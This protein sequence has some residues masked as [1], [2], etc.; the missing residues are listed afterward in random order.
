MKNIELQ[1]S[2]LLSNGTKTFDLSVPF[3]NGLVYGGELCPF[4]LPQEP[5]ERPLHWYRAEEF[6]AICDNQVGILPKIEKGIN[7]CHNL[8]AHGLMAVVKSRIDNAGFITLNRLISE[9]DCY[10]LLKFSDSQCDTETIKNEYDSVLLYLI[11]SIPMKIIYGNPAKIIT[12]CR[13]F[14]WLNPEK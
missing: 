4:Q 6:V 8:L 5:N 13:L 7:S 10:S 14:S 2:V 12:P 3:D 11:D 1:F 9:L